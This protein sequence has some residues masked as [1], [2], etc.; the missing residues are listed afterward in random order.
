MQGPAVESFLCRDY[1]IWLQPK[2]SRLWYQTHRFRGSEPFHHRRKA[3][4]PL[5]PATTEHELDIAVE[6]TVVVV[7]VPDVEVVGPA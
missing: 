4:K 3:E 5:H 7:L 1:Q 6:Q 2:G